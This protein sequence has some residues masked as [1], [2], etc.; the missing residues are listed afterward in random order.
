MRVLEAISDTNIGGAG[1][2]LCTRLKYS[3]RQRIHTTV[4]L[5]KGSELIS[6]LK[7]INIPIITLDGCY[8]QSLDW[9][10]IGK[11]CSILQRIRPHLVNCHGCLSFRIAAT[12]CRVPVVIYTRHCVYPVPTWQKLPII[13]QGIGKLQKI[14]SPNIIAVAEAA[15]DNLLQMGLSPSGIHVIINGAEGL[16]TQSFQARAATRNALGIPDTACVIGICARLEPCKG[17]MELLKA[18]QILLQADDRYHFLIIGGGSLDGVLKQFCKQK[19]IQQ[20][21]HFIGFVQDVSP[22]MNIVDIQVNCSNGTETSSLA[23]SEGMSLGKPSVVSNYGGNPH[24]VQHGINGFVYPLGN[25]T[26]LAKRIQQLAQNPLLYKRMATNAYHRY[27][28]EFNAKRMT[29]QTEAQYQTLFLR[30]VK[31]VRKKSSHLPI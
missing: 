4:I 17:H 7:Q 6:R 23:L 18:A 21:V 8:D 10:V 25:V 30:S 31:R 24:M 5:P 27:C 22:Y 29:T 1:V 26:A 2:L 14:L 20:H 9:K 12:L 15:K 13:K 16:K 19:H 28:T 11:L 3:N